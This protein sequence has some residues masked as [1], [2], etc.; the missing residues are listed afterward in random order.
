MNTFFL[1]NKTKLAK[2]KNSHKVL[3]TPPKK[4]WMIYF[5]LCNFFLQNKYDLKLWSRHFLLEIRLRSKKFQLK[6]S[7][8]QLFFLNALVLFLSFTSLYLLIYRSFFKEF[9]YSS[10]SQKVQSILKI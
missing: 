6:K 2:G 4:N 5:K 7:K 10:R 1:K 8:K 3:T 9:P